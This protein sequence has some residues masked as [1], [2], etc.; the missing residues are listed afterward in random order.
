M[1]WRVPGW[2]FVVVLVVL[3]ATGGPAWASF[4]GGNGTIV[5]GWRG[6]S[7]YR[8]APPSTAIRTVDPR[9]GLMHV[10]RDCPLGA[11]QP[12][13]YPNCAVWGPRFSPDGQKIA[14]LTLHT[15]PP[16]GGPPQLALDVVSPDGASLEAHSTENL[17]Q[18][19]AWSP[20]GDRFL[21]E[22]NPVGGS[23]IFL[24]ALDGAELSQLTPQATQW[25][26]WS[27]TGE[28]AY[29]RFRD[30]CP[31]VCSDLYVTR[32][33]GAERRLTY[34]GGSGPSWSPHGKKLAFVRGHTSGK[35]DIYLVGRDGRG[36]RRLTY[37]GGSS[38]AW[39]P[40]G[41]WIAFIRDVDL[42]V[43]RTNGR[44]LRRL[45]DESGFEEGGPAVRSVDW[46]ALP[47]R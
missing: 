10:L 3:Y 19:L 7:T 40:D 11:E 38:P 22:R 27:V 14:L 37:R 29:T 17:Y 9:S 44:G 24:A 34:R 5:Y 15:P 13:G 45:V 43:V 12:S 47:P 42:Y 4:P 39:S 25:P 33:G 28:I 20:A 30:P 8:S 35:A 2:F 36:L 46:Q 26:D 41:K 23:A 31:P 1:T 18:R 32:L 6:W 21:L 16:P